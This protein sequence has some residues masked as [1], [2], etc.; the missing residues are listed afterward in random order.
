M[1]SESS[2]AAQLWGTFGR[3]PL[4]WPCLSGHPSGS[5]ALWTVPGLH[6]S[7]LAGCWV[8]QGNLAA[9]STDLFQ[10]LSGAENHRV[11]ARQQTVSA[12]N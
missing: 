3:P 9:S 4:L 2:S 11:L 1:T 10:L 12:V 8:V 5:F 6:R 7:L